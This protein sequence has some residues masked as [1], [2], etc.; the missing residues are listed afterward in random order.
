MQ[1]LKLYIRSRF[2]ACLGS[3]TIFI[4][5]SNCQ[6]KGA[7]TQSRGSALSQDGEVKVESLG[8]LV[9][10]PGDVVEVVG[11]NLT[12][13]LTTKVG[14]VSVNLAVSSTT[15]ASFVMP[16][17]E[18]GIGLLDVSFQADGKE[19]QKL[20]L[21]NDSANDDLPILLVAPQFICSDITF[22]NAK[23]E[24]KQ[25]TRDCFTL[26]PV[27]CTVNGVTGCV[28]TSS[29]KAAKMAN[30]T[31]ANIKSGNTIL[32]VSGSAALSVANCSADGEGSC[33][34][35]GS[36]YKAAKLANFSAG[37]IRSGVTVAG[38]VGTQS[39][40]A[41]AC[42][43]NGEQGCETQGSYKALN[44]ASVDAAKMRASQTIIG[45]TGSI[46]NC[47]SGG[48][49]AC[50]VTGTYYAAAACSSDGASNCYVPGYVASS[51]PYKAINYDL[52]DVAK[53]RSSLT[54]AGK[55]GT[56]ADCASDGIAGCVSSSSFPS[57]NKSSFAATD[58]RS[59]RSLAG[60]S[61]TLG[62]C[63]ADG[64]SGCIAN[65]NFKAAST[66]AALQANIKSGVT[67]GGASGSMS[68]E[69]H[70]DCTGEGQTGCLATASFPTA[71][72]ANLTAA[73]IKLGTVIGGVTGTKR[74]MLVCKNG[75]GITGH[76]GTL[77][78][79]WDGTVKGQG[80]VDVTNGSTTVTGTSS[81]FTNYVLVG[82][83]IT[84]GGETHTVSS[85][86]N[87]TSLVVDQAY[88]QTLSAQT[89]THTSPSD[90]NHYI[91]D[92][93]SNGLTTGTRPGTIAFSSGSA[94]VTGT[95]TAFTTD[96]GPGDQITTS[97]SVTRTV[98][99]V[100]SDTSLTVNATYITSGSGTYTWNRINKTA[101][102]NCNED[103]FVDVTS[104]SS[105]FKPDASKSA[106]WTRIFQDQM[107]GLYWSNMLSNNVNWT[108]ALSMCSSLN[109]GTGGNNWR[110]PSEKE[111]IQAYIDGVYRNLSGGFLNSG[112]LKASTTSTLATFNIKGIAFSDGTNTSNM[113][114]GIGSGVL[115]VRE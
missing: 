74:E 19:L 41:A 75:K 81:F 49:Q 82:D 5:A 100:S 25:G 89:Y 76:G 42:S 57:A 65:S 20:A 30:V 110:M 55:Q 63:T 11:A 93:Q 29:Y 96:L 115:C 109:G 78:T 48:G 91:E 107:T 97:T 113:T 9:A 64:Q 67:L 71:A 44:T 33:T 23:G 10:K 95:G 56:I 106:V 102:G 53:M 32:G 61:G 37:D 7:G 47:S 35:D 59:G 27:N 88:A 98:V 34:V 87:N 104:S 114:K 38:V 79:V 112:A 105:P 73:N 84:I 3:A 21:V 66:A 85:I 15:S 69:S 92:Y 13:S 6:S 68:V 2:R 60:V 54:I 70:S 62:S 22:R 8:T 83:Q 50:Y 46:D 58:L 26:A 111:M 28:A 18:A 39:G 72:A 90:T 108:T 94:V 40:P 45:V 77:T 31:A 4:L 1:Y 12:S 16:G 24:V 36:Q 103:N 86:T 14:G 17:A 43:S 80:T 51:H 101:R 99:S 52:I